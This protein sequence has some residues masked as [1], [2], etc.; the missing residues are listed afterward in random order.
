MYN[1]KGKLDNRTLVE[2]YLPLVKKIA[3]GIYKKINFTIELDDLIQ[4]GTIGLMDAL[5]K[6]Q[7]NDSATFETYATT[8]IRG[9]IMDELRRND[10]LSQEDRQLFRT[11]QEHTKNL[12][13]KGN[14]RPTEA[15]VAEAA[16]VSIDDYFS[17]MTKNEVHSFVSLDEHEEAIQISSEEEEVEVTIHKK[18]LMRVVANGIK[19][20]NEKE[21]V[22][23]QLMYVEELTAKEA[24]FVMELTPARISQ[25]HAAAIKKLQEHCKSIA[26]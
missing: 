8:R 12:Q 11:I 18:Q 22:M 9:S 26:E 19:R 17:V 20:L 7:P 4:C 2:Q 3:S 5:H 21:Q 14:Y 25:M 16:G 23:M 6:Y 1:A 24:A 10:H 15:E 13:G